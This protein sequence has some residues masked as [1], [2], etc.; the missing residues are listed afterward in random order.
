MGQFTTSNNQSN[1]GKRRDSVHLETNTPLQRS[2]NEKEK[3][4]LSSYEVSKEQEGVFFGGGVGVERGGGEGVTYYSLVGS[5]V[6]WMAGWL[7]CIF[8]RIFVSRARACVCVCVSGGGGEG[9]AMICSYPEWGVLWTK[10][11]GRNHT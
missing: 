4:S 8:I 3:H 9:G 5:S 2:N 7:G 10:W 6:V 11:E 1:Q